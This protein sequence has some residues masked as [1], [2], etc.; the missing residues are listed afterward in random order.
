[1]INGD[2]LKTFKNIEAYILGKLNESEVDE[3]WVEFL[4]S[5]EWYDLFETELLLRHLAQHG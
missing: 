3:L 4:K 2:D 1:M 5:P